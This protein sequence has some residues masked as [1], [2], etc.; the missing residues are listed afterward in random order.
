MS[1]PAQESPEARRA[2]I[3]R[4]W[5]LAGALFAFVVL[6]FVVTIVRLKGNVAQY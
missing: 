5:M 2:R 3:R 6:V 4:N 1:H